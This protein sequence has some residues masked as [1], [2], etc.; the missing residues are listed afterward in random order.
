MTPYIFY[1]KRFRDIVEELKYKTLISDTF[2]QG[3]LNKEEIQL[4]CCNIFPILT[5]NEFYLFA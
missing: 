5:F 3:G 2:E 1:L 4:N